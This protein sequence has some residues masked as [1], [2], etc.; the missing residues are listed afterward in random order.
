MQLN[1][2]LKFPQAHIRTFGNNIVTNSLTSKTSWNF[3]SCIKTQTSPDV[4]GKIQPECMVCYNEL[5][6]LQFKQFITRNIGDMLLCSQCYSVVD[7]IP[8]QG[9]QGIWERKINYWILST[10]MKIILYHNLM[11]ACIFLGDSLT[12]ASTTIIVRFP[13]LKV[14]HTIWT[15]LHNKNKWAS[16]RCV[17]TTTTCC[18]MEFQQLS[19]TF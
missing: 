4:S 13:L 11:G 8:Y 9:F 5:L 2:N 7:S 12:S 19:P 17:V 10:W 3:S 1:L 6:S 15:H 18:F 14:D 16:F